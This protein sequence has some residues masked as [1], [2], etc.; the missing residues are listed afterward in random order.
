M[1]VSPC[2]VKVFPSTVSLNYRKVISF[3][4][5]QRRGTFLS[6]SAATISL[7]TKHLPPDFTQQ[8]LLDTLRQESDET[9]ALN[10]FQWALEQPEFEPSRRVFEEVLRKLGK[11]GSF[12]AM[13]RVLDDMKESKVE[14]GEGT[15]FIFIERYAMFELYDEAIGVLDV[16]GHEFGVKPGIF[17]FNLLLNVLVDGN[18]LKL[19]ENVLS[20]MLSEGLNPDVSTYNILI[21]ALCKEGDVKK[22]GNVMQTMTSNWCEP[23]VFTYGT[24]IQGLCKSGGVEVATRLL[25]TI[26]MK[27]MALA[28]Q[29]Y[30]PI[31]LAL[32]RQKRAKEAMRL[33]REMEEKADPPDY[34]S[35]KIVFRGLCSGGGPIDE[36]V[37]FAVEMMEKGYVPKF[38]SFSILAEE[39][40]AL[41]REETLVKLIDMI[42]K[43]AD[44]SDNQ[45]LIKDFLK[46]RNFQ[47]ALATLSRVLNSSYPQGN[48]VKGRMRVVDANGKDICEKGGEKRL[49]L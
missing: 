35:H 27:G 47:D 21:K 46:T 12:G 6:N 36:A 25:I 39:L 48:L 38:S 44:I 49:Y 28:P 42:M 29:A 8:Q 19:V 33:F 24:L 20:R 14:I 5:S 15:F 37:N 31:I 43:K 45:G 4:L 22:A 9:S 16:M 26:Q 2:L 11:A 32:F 1:A 17:S 40:L 34:V 18:K 13:R 3:T 30:N 23:D 7:K 10:L 41:A